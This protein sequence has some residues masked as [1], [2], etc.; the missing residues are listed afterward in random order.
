MLGSLIKISYVLLC[1]HAR[2]Y[3][4]VLRKENYTLFT[5]DPL[6]VNSVHCITRS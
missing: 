5:N 4:Y 1:P 6:G 2:K 3:L